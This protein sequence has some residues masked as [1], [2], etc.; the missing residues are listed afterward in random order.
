MLT[1][2]GTRH[3]RRRHPFLWLLLMAALLMGTALATAITPGAGKAGSAR[4]DDAAAPPAPSGVTAVDGNTPGVVVLA[5]NVVDSA[6]YYRIG[7]VSSE[8]V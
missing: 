5:W 4:A 7:W 3:R 6:A 1:E 2:T 8:R